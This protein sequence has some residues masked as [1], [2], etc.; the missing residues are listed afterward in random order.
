MIL[1][2]ILSSALA[3]EHSRKPVELKDAA[4]M[5][6]EQ[7]SNGVVPATSQKCR[8]APVSN[9]SDEDFKQYP[10]GGHG[11]LFFGN[12]PFY[13][14]HLPLWFQPHNFQAIYEV[15]F[16]NTVEGQKM[17]ELFK[18]RK[19][20]GFATFN[21]SQVFKIPQFNCMTG[22]GE[23]EL[24]GELF[25]GH[26]ERD[27]ESLGDVKL[28]V[29]RR[30]YYKELSEKPASASAS[31]VDDYIVFGEGNQFF[32][33]KVI[34]RKPAVDHIMPLEN[35]IEAFRKS[36][37]GASHSCFT[38]VKKE[39]QMIYKP[40]LCADPTAPKTIITENP[41][42]NFKEFYYETGDLR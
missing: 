8:P 15:D 35:S 10:K 24:P 20:Q 33:A 17:K 36:V 26:F 32:S 19:N 37:G 40:K 4:Q 9:C 42:T 31:D 41:E 12:G 34:E 3:G 6:I 1:W 29:K 13:I 5:A 30:I 2:L 23:K 16:P 11:Q 18:K 25:Q 28:I 14:S 27:G 38:A 21:P 22:L 7:L 39:A